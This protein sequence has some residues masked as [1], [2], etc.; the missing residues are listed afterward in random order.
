M[1]V[2]QTTVYQYDELSDKAKAKARDWY[3]QAG[4]GDNYFSE[5]VIEDASKIAGL[6]GIELKQR[7]IRTMGGN[8]RQEPAISWSGFSQQGDGASF[9]GKLVSLETGTALQRVTDYA[10]QDETLACYRGRDWTHCK[11]RY[12]NR[13]CRNDPDKRSLLP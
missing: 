2:I 6:L 8:T 9:E 3:R 5:S 12:E 1:R 13:L 4:D 7:E 10:P 11:L